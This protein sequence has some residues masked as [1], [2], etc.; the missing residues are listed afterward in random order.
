VFRA[1]LNRLVEAP[2]KHPILESLLLF[3]AQVALAPSLNQVGNQNT[4]D[5]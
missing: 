1:E 2:V 4:D 3:R 5:E